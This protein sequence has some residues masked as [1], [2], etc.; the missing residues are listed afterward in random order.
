MPLDTV[1][2]RTA[3]R[4]IDIKTNIKFNRKT[5]KTKSMD[6]MCHDRHDK[7]SQGILPQKFL[8]WQIPIIACFYTISIVDLQMPMWYSHLP[9]QRYFHEPYTTTLKTKFTHKKWNK[10]DLGL[11][12]QK[13]IKLSGKHLVGKFEMI[14]LQKTMSVYGDVGSLACL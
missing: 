13:C 11:N 6:N 10:P 9:L 2:W 8:G 3:R 4:K 12:I 14:F 1:N 5:D 7:P